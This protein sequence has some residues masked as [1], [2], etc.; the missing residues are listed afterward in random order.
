MRITVVLEDLQ[1][2]GANRVSL[3]RAARWAAAGDQVTVFATEFGETGPA[4][5]VPPEL[6]LQ[7]GTGRPRQ[8]RT[9]LPIALVALVRRARRSDLVVSGTEVGFGLLLGW[10][11]AR[12]A[13]RPFAVTVQ[14]RVDRAVET[15]VMGPLRPLTRWVLAHADLAV[16]VARG[17]V[18]ALR[19]LGLPGART[20]VVLNAVPRDEI[21]AAAAE[22]AEPALLEGVPAGLPVV[23][24]SG[25]LARQKGFDLLLRADARARAAGAPPHHLVVLGEGEE[26][27]ALIELAADLGLTG[28]VSFPGFAENPHALVAGATLFVVSSRW[29]GFPLSLAE[30]LACG[31]P[32]LAFDCVAGPAE[33]LADGRYGALVPAE[34]VEALARAIAAHLLDPQPLRD[35]AARAPGERPGLF[36]PDRAAADH[37]AAL[38]GLLVR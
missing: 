6:Q 7:R 22:A 28:S 14:S 13:R 30:A 23:V 8:L 31:T 18:P 17:V 20:E 26:R 11:A 1:D 10:L 5:P 2:N 19:D 25:R 38:A 16:C 34:D 27:A 12:L 37:R 15:Y 32:C 9:A 35:A 4:V 3:D 24:S 21:L 36:S 33:A 29:E